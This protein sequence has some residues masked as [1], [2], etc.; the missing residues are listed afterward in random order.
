[1]VLTPYV[2]YPAQLRL[3][4]AEKIKGPT[5]FGQIFR[6]QHDKSGKIRLF[7]AKCTYEV[8][9]GAKTVQK[10]ATKN[11]QPLFMTSPSIEVLQVDACSCS[12]A[13]QLTT[14]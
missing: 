11:L 4:L 6:Y 14:L 3:T 1:L 2:G 8:L 9:A 5:K 7:L 10:N 12:S 13:V